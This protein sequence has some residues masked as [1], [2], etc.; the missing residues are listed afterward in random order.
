[1]TETVTQPAREAHSPVPPGDVRVLILCADVG[2]GHVT[3]ARAL[4]RRLEHHP[5]VAAV[6]LRTD[7]E[8]MGRTLGR[9]LTDGFEVHLDQIGWTYDLAY[10][11]FFERALP[12]RAAHLALAALGGRG[13]RHT[14]EAFNADVVVTEYPVLSAALGELR[15]LGRLAVPVCSSISDPAG[16]FYWAHRGIDVHLLSWAESLEEVGQIAGPGRAVAIRP[17][18]DPRF[19]S[20]LARSAARATLSLPADGTVVLVSGGG[21][22]LGDLA[23]AARTALDAVPD[24]LVV[25]LA[26]RNEPLKQRLEAQHREDPRVEVL[27]FTDRM[28][29]LLA[30]ADVLVH[31]TG[32]TTAL[33]ARIVGCPLINFGT[34]PAHVRAHARAL[35][36]RGVAEWAPGTATLTGALERTLARS[37]PRPLVTS[38]LPDAAEVVVEVARAHSRSSNRLPHY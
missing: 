10:R 20:A 31:T 22:G 5:G 17:L 27:G 21:W 13:L 33:E 34:G 36:E 8:V 18:V 12:R 26:G 24:A 38:R 30:A 32:G 25:C 16:L 2:E 28:P 23:G 9:F 15:A 7:L 19:E 4:A 14:I 3:V 35:A 29:E 37:R 6:A 11:V 1:M